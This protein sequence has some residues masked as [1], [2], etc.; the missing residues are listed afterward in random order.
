MLCTF[1]DDVMAEIKMIIGLGN[2]GSEYADTRH[3]IGFMVIDLLS[4]ALGIKLKRKKFGALFG[5]GEFADKKLIL[6]KPM[7]YMNRSGQVVSTAV[8]FYKLPL[9]DL[10]IITDDM[11][12]EPGMIRLRTKGSAG[13]H[14]GMADIIEKLGTENVNRLRV[15]IGQNGKMIAEDYVL[16]CPMD[17][18][19]PL[20]DKAIASAKEAVICWLDNGIDETMTRFNCC[21]SRQS[22]E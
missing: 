18:E 13:G 22:E 11:A 8:G 10:L 16:A 5:Q 14:N 2:P 1:N 3:N 17:T 20:L 6:L 15:G 19:K 4:R 9:E 21:S 7:Q 12:L